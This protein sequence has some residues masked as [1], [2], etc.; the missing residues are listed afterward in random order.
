MKE[1]DEI[2]FVD[3]LKHHRVVATQIQKTRN[4]WQ[5]YSSWF[6]VAQREYYSQYASIYAE[7]LEKYGDEKFGYYARRIR[8]RPEF[9]GNSRASMKPDDRKT[10]IS[11]AHLKGY[12]CSKTSNGEYGNVRPSEIF[13]CF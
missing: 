6:S 8:L 3:Q 7:S 5:Q 1:Y 11:M 2:I 13:Y 4:N 10:Q 9:S 12:K